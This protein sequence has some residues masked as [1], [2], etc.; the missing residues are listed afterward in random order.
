[1]A[2]ISRAGLS[3]DH[4]TVVP[5]KFDTTPFKND[6]V[7][8][9]PV[10]RN[11]Q[12]VEIANEL[13]KAGIRTDF[14]G[15]SDVGV[16]AYSN[17]YFTSREYLDKHPKIVEAF[18]YGVLGGWRL[19]QENPA[20]AARIVAKY[21]RETPLEVIEQSVRETNI[22]VPVPG[23][24]RIGVMSLEGWQETDAVFRNAAVLKQTIQIVQRLNGE[25]PA[26]LAE[27]SLVFT[28]E[29]VE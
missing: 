1:M 19:A 22:L 24:D 21:D 5:V 6:E 17:T 4:L 18:M 16:Q 28:N 2:M 29:F 12:G 23:T 15:P 11:T 9:Y 8:A 10:F 3:S 13:G 26:R 20:E 27:R 14:V 7:V 25:I